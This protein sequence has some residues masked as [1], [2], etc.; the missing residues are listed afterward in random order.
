MRIIR[1]RSGLISIVQKIQEQI[2]NSDYFQR[3]IA[4][5]IEPYYT[6]VI[7]KDYLGSA[8]D[9]ADVRYDAS[10]GILYGMPVHFNGRFHEICNPVVLSKGEMAKLS[11]SARR[12]RIKRAKKLAEV[13]QNWITVTDSRN[14][15]AG[16]YGIVG[17]DD[18]RRV[19]GMALSQ[20]VTTDE[21][22]KYIDGLN[23]SSFVNARIKEI[24]KFLR[25]LQPGSLQDCWSKSDLTVP[26]HLLV[27]LKSAGLSVDRKC[28]VH[29]T[30]TGSFGLKKPYKMVAYEKPEG[31]IRSLAT[32]IDYICMFTPHEKIR[33][34]KN[35]MTIVQYVDGTEREIPYVDNF[36]YDKFYT[37]ADEMMISMML[38]Y[39]G[40]IVTTDVSLALIDLYFEAKQG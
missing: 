37:N 1:S 4:M 26:T 8:C 35:R 14:Q 29:L 11:K 17:D 6:I 7:T 19:L 10:T 12:S 5:N 18:F 31:Y 3:C 21:L 39:Y 28:E 24:P 13:K 34:Y 25:D 16:V 36:K 30:R 40:V 38:A 20:P 32:Y 33:V 23:E 9:Y 27:Q 2:E 22:H 15:E